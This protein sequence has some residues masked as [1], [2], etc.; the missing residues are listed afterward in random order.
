[1]KKRTLLSVFLSLMLIFSLSACGSKDSGG[2]GGSGGSSTGG[3]LYD[4]TTISAEE[5][6]E[7]KVSMDDIKWSFENQTKYDEEN[8][9]LTYENNTGYDLVFFY[10]DFAL[11]RDLTEEQQSE[12]HKQLTEFNGLTESDIDETR[13]SDSH[14]EAGWTIGP[15]S[16][17]VVPD[18]ESLAVEMRCYVDYKGFKIDS[19][20]MEYFE[21][22]RAKF[23]YAD[24]DDIRSFEYTF[25]T[26]TY[27]EEW[28]VV[29]GRYW[30][31]SDLAKSLPELPK[32]KISV[33]AEEEDDTDTR[34]DVTVG[35]VSEEDYK[36]YVKAC[37][38]EG[39]E[40]DAEETDGEYSATNGEYQLHLEYLD[41]SEGMRI[42]VV[43]LS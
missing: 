9:Y 12:L 37:K 1:M 40:E 3:T 7:S 22:L 19:A 17:H 30:S 14:V 33:L 32:D 18:G 27:E 39:Y 26:D 34:F 16:M 25:A 2:S 8:G 6:T 20:L 11:K 10:L 36:D 43:P 31:D 38:K 24:G 23:S 42:Q 29:N 13:Y 28:S 21:P 41:G 4:R 5:G 35:K 15:G